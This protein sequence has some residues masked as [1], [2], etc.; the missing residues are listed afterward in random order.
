MKKTIALIIIGALA[1]AACSTA[2]TDKFVASVNN[3]NRGVE[4]VDASIA[5]VSATLY[6]NCTGMQAVA[7]AASDVAGTCSKAGGVL[8][9][10]NSVIINFCQNSNVVDI[11]SAV[12]AT[13]AS[14]SAAKSQLSS[15]KAA[16]VKGT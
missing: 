13:A 5:Q 4:A 11:S 15:V 12:V 3:F 14:V 16:C 2:Q 1:L 6:K 10:A 8:S 7:Q 9:A